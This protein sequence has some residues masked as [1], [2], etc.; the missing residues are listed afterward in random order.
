LLEADP[1]PEAAPAALARGLAEHAEVAAE[2]ARM[3]KVDRERD[4]DRHD[5]LERDPESPRH[6]AFYLAAGV[7]DRLDSAL[8]R[9]MV[10]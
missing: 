8:A 9:S 1:V 4:R 5:R 3:A 6:A 7:G 2:V 10:V